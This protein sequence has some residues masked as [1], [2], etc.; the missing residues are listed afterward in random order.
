MK[1]NNIFGIVNSHFNLSEFVVHA[2]ILEINF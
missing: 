2:D 1:C